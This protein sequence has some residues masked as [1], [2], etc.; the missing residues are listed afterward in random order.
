MQ[1][2]EQKNKKL[3]KLKIKK[4]YPQLPVIT[5]VDL[6]ASAIEIIDGIDDAPHLD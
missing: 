5:S 6:Y 2:N 1:V 3:K 4:S